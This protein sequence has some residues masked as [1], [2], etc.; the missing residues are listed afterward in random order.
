[1]AT[2]RRFVAGA[3]V[4]EVD[5]R[6][7]A[8]GDSASGP[9]AGRSLQLRGAVPQTGVRVY[10]VCSPGVG[11]SAVAPTAPAWVRAYANPPQ[12]NQNIV[13]WDD[14]NTRCIREFE[15]EGRASA[16]GEWA[17]VLDGVSTAATGYTHD[18]RVSPV[19]DM[20]H[21]IAVPGNA[22]DW[23]YRVRA[24]DYWGREGAWAQLDASERTVHAYDG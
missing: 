9:G 6:A 11:P 10:H 12:W 23:S 7:V 19:S 4:G 15:V 21:G 5:V 8:T 24:V 3:A 17:S 16:S 13:V 18:L 1:M 20:H 22:T 14:T 2:Q